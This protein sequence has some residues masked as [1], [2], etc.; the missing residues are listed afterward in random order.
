MDRPSLA[1][2]APLLLICCYCSA[3]TAPLLLPLQVITR[4]ASQRIAEFA[5]K[6]A[7]EHGRKTVCAVHK[8]TIMCVADR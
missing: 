6:Y 2:T 3:A 4:T 7:E 8:A 5:F 1:A